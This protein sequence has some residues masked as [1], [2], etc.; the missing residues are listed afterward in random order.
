LIRPILKGEVQSFAV[1]EEASAK[2]N[3]WVQTRLARTVWNHCQSFYRRDSTTGKNFVTFP[4]HVALFWWLAR[5]P[6]YSEYLIVGGERWRRVRRLKGILR[7]TLGLA[8]LMAVVGTLCGGKGLHPFL[9][10]VCSYWKY[11]VQYSLPS[12]CPGR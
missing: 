8:V 5:R 12:W 3:S 7:V 2:Y 4:G 10:R 6:R 1:R 9:E 11:A